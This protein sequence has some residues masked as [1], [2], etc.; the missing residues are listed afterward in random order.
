MTTLADLTSQLDKLR[1]ARASG[2]RSIADGDQR[3]EYKTD[4]EM[5]SA[6][7]AIEQQI[8]AIGGKPIRTVRIATSK[9]T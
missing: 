5:A 3:I 7:A 1:M 2:L 8:A 4:A 6:I 9:G